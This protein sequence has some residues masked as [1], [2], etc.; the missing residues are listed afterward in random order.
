[1]RL[2]SLNSDIFDVCRGNVLYALF[3][4]LLAIALIVSFA[5]HTL[6]VFF[7]GFYFI[8]FFSCL[9][10]SKNKAS[11]F[12]NI[13]RIFIYTSLVYFLYS[14]LAY[15]NYQNQGQ[16]FIFSDQSYFYDVGDS[17]K[18]L[19]SPIDIFESITANRAYRE[20]YAM[21]IFSGVIAYIAEKYFYGNSVILQSLIVVSFAVFTNIFLYKILRF[22]VE[23]KPAYIYT[24]L[25]SFFSAVFAYSPWI[26]RDIHILFFYT[27][28]FYLIHKKFRLRTLVLLFIIQYVVSELRL[29]NGLAFFFFPLLYVYT[30]GK[31]NK[32]RKLIYFFSFLVFIL[33]SIQ[34]VSLINKV[35]KEIVNYQS[36]TAD[37]VGSAG[38]LGSAIYKLPVGLKQLAVVTYSQMQPFPP[39]GEVEN[40][41]TV[42]ELLSS[43]FFGVTAVFWFYVVYVS[44]I[45]FIKNYNRIPKALLLSIMF[46]CLFLLVSTSN[47]N[48]RRIMAVYPII[49]VFFV[50]SQTHFNTMLTIRKRRLAFCLLYVTLLVAYG[51][52][53]YK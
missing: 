44:V 37:S 23:R 16:F 12:K 34:S 41:N 48:V 1:M 5:D 11:E 40:P 10:Y 52:L 50:F 35:S 26:L 17:V 13:F 19:S 3:A 43:A 38:G 45:S 32:Y 30:K 21:H 36:Y 8:G 9:Y 28:G 51:F 6:V 2:I 24:L 46:C 53:K 49:Y 18:E 4:L 33:I 7:L 47:M 25:F 20:S 39:W 14:I 15:I 29:A 42:F 27:V 31:E 22:Y